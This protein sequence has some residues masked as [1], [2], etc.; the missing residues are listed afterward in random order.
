MSS[1]GGLAWRPAR[2]QPPLAAD[3][4]R[5]LADVGIAGD[6]HADA[7]SPRQLLLAS[8]QA[9]E[10]LGLP[11]HALRENLLLDFDTACLGSG[12]V[13]QVGEQVRLRVMFQCEACGQLDAMAPRLAQRIGNRRGVLARVLKGGVVQ[14]GDPV[15]ALGLLEAAWSDDWRARVRQVLDAMPDGS[16]IEYRQLARLAGIQSTYCRAFPRLLAGLGPRYA[17]QAVA[18]N[19]RVALPRWQGEGLFAQEA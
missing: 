1:V 6:L 5:L 12:T 10:D 17:A 19:S 3:S 9:Y 14:R 16:V 7:R 13:L 11:P 4:L 8:S 18:A 2:G 15:R